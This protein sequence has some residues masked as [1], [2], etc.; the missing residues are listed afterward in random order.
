MIDKRRAG[1]A[2]GRW[3]E[4]PNGAV[5]STADRNLFQAIRQGPHGVVEA[6][7]VRY[8]IRPNNILHRLF[9]QAKA[10]A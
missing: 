3:S 4:T 10:D 6:A 9:Q 5:A 8:F 2:L 1:R 7:T